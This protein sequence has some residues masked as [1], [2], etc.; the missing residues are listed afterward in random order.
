MSDTTWDVVKGALV[1][2]APWIAGTLGTPLAGTAV[3]VLEQSLG[4]T[5]SAPGKS[6]PGQILA[7]LQ[8]ATPEQLMAVKQCENN[9]QEFMQKLG[10]DS[11][12]TLEKLAVD[13]RIS[14]RQLQISKPSL[15]PDI[16]AVLVILGFV[17]V[18]IIKIAGVPI[19]TDPLL[20]DLMTTHR[21]SVILILSFYFGSSS[22]QERISHIMATANAGIVNM[23][24]NGGK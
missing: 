8:G 20:Q 16:L 13:D 22:G 1:Q 9:H 14:A 7:A 11:V 2:F 18:L 15:L 21:D 4:L 6:S 12:M 23:N 5:N 3:A 10:Y 19:P 24:T 17:A